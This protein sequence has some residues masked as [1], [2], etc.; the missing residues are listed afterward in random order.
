MKIFVAVALAVAFQVVMV[1]TASAH[2][3]GITANATCQ[4][5]TAVISYNAFS[6]DFLTVSGSNTEIDIRFNGTTVDSKPFT[7][8]SNPPNQF[9]GSQSSQLTGQVTVEAFVAGTWGDNF[10]NGQSADVLVTMPTDCGSTPGT[11]RFTGGGK[12][13]D[14]GGLSITK[15]LT[16]H[17]DLLLSNN[18]EINWKGHQFHMLVH[19][20][21]ICSDDPN[22]IQA[23]PAAPLDTMVGVGTG[24]YDGDDGFTVEFTLVDAGEPGTSDKAAFKIY[25]TANPSNIVLN[26]PL[27]VLTGGNLQAHFDQPHKH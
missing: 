10:A 15:G 22:I 11:G 14:V 19:T 9:T 27:T 6:W 20:S 1:G 24:T 16:I 2:S 12:Q 3:V 17:C 8:A 4:N 26:L 18:L 25:E 7:L 21:A 13:I 23:P 5:N